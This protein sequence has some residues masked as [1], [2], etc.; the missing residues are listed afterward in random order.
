MHFIIAP[1]NTTYCTSQYK[2][3]FSAGT[4]QNQSE[5]THPHPPVLS[6]AI[7]HLSLS[8]SPTPGL[9]NCS[10]LRDSANYGFCPA[11]EREARFTLTWQMMIRVS[12]FSGGR[13]RRESSCGSRVADVCRPSRYPS[14][15][16]WFSPSQSGQGQNIKLDTC[17]LTFSLVSFIFSSS[18]HSRQRVSRDPVF[19]GWGD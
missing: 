10:H 2:D 11:R 16:K 9:Q 17:P 1:A 13:S 18:F 7:F 15:I 4:P 6:M 14:W 19:C 5:P 8:R 12:F 3:I